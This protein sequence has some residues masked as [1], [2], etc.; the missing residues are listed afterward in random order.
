MGNSLHIQ[1]DPANPLDDRAR[2]S[3]GSALS[4]VGPEIVRIRA[5]LR[6]L[7]EEHE[8][9]REEWKALRR[10]PGPLSRWLIFRRPVLWKGRKEGARGG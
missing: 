4:P 8:S 1:P 7:H 3:D 5:E 2:L 9:L 6:R 10:G